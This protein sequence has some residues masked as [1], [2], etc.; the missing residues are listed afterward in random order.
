MVTRAGTKAASDIEFLGCYMQ[1]MPLQ[2]FVVNRGSVWNVALP[3]HEE[4]W[5]VN[6]SNRLCAL[7]LL[8]IV[9]THLCPYNDQPSEPCN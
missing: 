3:G 1:Q 2:M 9:E 7:R 8:C 5:N 4:R 6:S